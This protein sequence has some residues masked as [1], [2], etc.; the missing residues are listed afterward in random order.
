MKI[1]KP[2]FDISRFICRANVQQASDIR[3]SFKEEV[4]ICYSKDQC[5]QSETVA[6]P[7]W[8]PWSPWK[9]CSVEC[10][11]GHQNRTRYCEGRGCQ[12]STIEIRQCSRRPCSGEW[13]CWSEWSPCNVS[14]GWGVQTRTRTCLTDNCK[15]V[16]RETQPCEVVPCECKLGRYFLM[17]PLQYSFVTALLGWE[18]WSAWSLCDENNEQHRKRKCRTTN[19][20]IGVCQGSSFETRICVTRG[21]QGE[22]DAFLNS[23]QYIE[24]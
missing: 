16:D 8:S 15:G 4:Q 11:T 1:F 24:K 18:N 19:P 5:Y 13:A 6:K 10:G 21:P 7:K 22:F 23:Q 9:E 2:S 12:G 17:I 14:C 3:L 20:A